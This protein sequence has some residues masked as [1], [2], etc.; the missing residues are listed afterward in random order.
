MKLSSATASPSIIVCLGQMLYL[1][2]TLPL[3]LISRV[4]KAY[5]ISSVSDIIYDLSLNI[6]HSEE[7]PQQQQYHDSVGI[8]SRD[9]TIIFSGSDTAQC[10]ITEAA[11]MEHVYKQ[12]TLVHPKPIPSIISTIVAVKEERSKNTIENALYCRDIIKGLITSS[13]DSDIH[14]MLVTSDYHM[15]RAKLLFEY[16]CCVNN[17]DPDDDDHYHH[18]NTITV[19]C[20]PANSLHRRFIENSDGVLCSY[21]PRVDRSDDSNEW[22]L[23]E[24][25]DWELNALLSV[26]SQMGKYGLEAISKDHITRAI[27][28]LKVM[29]Y[30]YDDSMDVDR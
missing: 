26:N 2:Q 18:N 27:Q 19:T 13:R 21:R 25:L 11:A 9:L 12:L 1:N 17:D 16:I 6:T 10:G 22:T 24:R 14:I 5:E 29:N 20:C 8:Q 3:S 4:E 15:P 7:Q 28:Q 23:S 30:T